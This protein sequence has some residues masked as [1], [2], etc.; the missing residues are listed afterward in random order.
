MKWFST[1]ILKLLLNNGLIDVADKDEI[2][3][4]FDK[5][6]ESA[7]KSENILTKKINVFLKHPLGVLTSIFLY[8]VVGTKIQKLQRSNDVNEMEEQFKN[9]FKSKMYSEMLDAE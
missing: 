9:E 5:S 2:K 3:E 8:V 4:S 7:E 6:F 1:L